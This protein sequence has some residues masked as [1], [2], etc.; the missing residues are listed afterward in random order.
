MTIEMKKNLFRVR[1]CLPESP[2]LHLAALLATNVIQSPLYK[3]ILHRIFEVY[4]TDTTVERIEKELTKGFN[5]DYMRYG[6]TD[7]NGYVIRGH[8]NLTRVVHIN[9]FFLLNGEPYA[10]TPV[11]KI[12]LAQVIAG[13][14]I[15]ECVH[16]LHGEVNPGLDH[17]TESPPQKVFNRMYSDSGQLAER[18]LW[19]GDLEHL[20][21]R[22]ALPGVSLTCAVEAMMLVTHG[23]E[24][25]VVSIDYNPDWFSK[26]AMSVAINLEFP[27]GSAEDAEYLQERMSV[28]RKQIDPVDLREVPHAATYRCKTGIVQAEVSSEYSAPSTH[29]FTPSPPPQFLVLYLLQVE[30]HAA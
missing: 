8:P 24:R 2:V 20:E 9:C 29:L 17:C 12:R 27:G 25:N 22:G 16:V 19:G 30:A 18:F 3:N 1:E 5:I 4:K 6:N 23:V 11:Q 26:R 10:K 21:P 28:G 14:L 7:K 15:H 13:V